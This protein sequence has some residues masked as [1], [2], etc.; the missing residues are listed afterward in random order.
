MLGIILIFLL[1]S[2]EHVWERRAPNR[3]R[4]A[5]VQCQDNLVHLRIAIESFK[6]DHHRLPNS[7]DELKQDPRYYENVLWF[8]CPLTTPGERAYQYQA[9]PN[10]PEN[11]LV[12]CARHGQ[13][14][15]VLQHNGLLRLP[16]ESQRVF[17]ARDAAASAENVEAAP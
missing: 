13:G 6:K 12:T 7:L 10:S 8:T 17:P 5:Y 14:L 3:D 4:Q 1:L 15:L 16:K 9:D 2:F 11:P